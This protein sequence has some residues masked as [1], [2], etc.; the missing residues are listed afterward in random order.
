MGFSHLLRTEVA[1]AN[2]RAEFAIPIDADVCQDDNIVLERRPYVV[3]FLLM[4]ILEGGVRFPV[5]PLIL[6]T[7]KFYGMYPDQLPPNF[8]GVVSSVSRLNNLYGQRLDQHDIN[9]MYSLCGNERSVYY[10]NVRDTLVRLI[11][12]LPNFKGNSAVEF[13]RVSGNWLANE[14]TYLI[15]P[16]DI[17]R[18][19]LIY[20]CYQCFVIYLM[21][22]LFLFEG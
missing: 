9:F 13:V 12:C 20:Y 10:L 4:P 16:R 5:D 2:F 19:L 22:S 17:G 7:L 3:F 15:S 14:L 8:Y 11:L 1:L 21:L 18:Y 6:R